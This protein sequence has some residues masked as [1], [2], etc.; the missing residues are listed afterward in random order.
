[1]E[2]VEPMTPADP[3]RPPGPLKRLG[4]WGD[5]LLLRSLPEYHLFAS[6]ELRARGIDELDNEL[7]KSKGFWRAMMVIWIALIVISNASFCLVPIFMPWRFPGRTAAVIAIEVLIAVAL[8]L[9]IWRRGVKRRLRGKLIEQGVPVCRACGY[10]MRGLATIS[11][12]L[13]CP[14]CGEASDPEVRALLT[15]SS[16]S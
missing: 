1:M 11:E 16:P 9:W 14:E 10:C 2:S 15:A 12:V 3:P 4:Q 13:R 7:D 8:T 6:D 5:R